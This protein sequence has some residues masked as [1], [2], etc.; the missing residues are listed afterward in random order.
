MQHV[1]M[2]QVKLWPEVG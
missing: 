1:F 2:I